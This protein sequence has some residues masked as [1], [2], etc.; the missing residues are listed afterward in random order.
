MYD[1]RAMAFELIE[2]SDGHATTSTLLQFD[3]SSGPY[4]A[5]YTGPNVKFGHVIVSGN[6]MLYYAM[7]AEGSMS[8]GYAKVSFDVFEGK[9][10]MILNWQWL[11]GDKSS[12]VSRWRHIPT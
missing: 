5:I 1:L 9:T 12:G 10:E 6:E 4:R 11:T 7:D 2:N 8:S 3:S